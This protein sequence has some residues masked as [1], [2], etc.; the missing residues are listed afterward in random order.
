MIKEFLKGTSK[1]T[2]PVKLQTIVIYSH[3]PPR[4]ITGWLCVWIQNNAGG[5]KV[6]QLDFG[7]GDRYV[8]L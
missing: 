2:L 1:N 3:P 7:E 6:E 4:Q 5:R 8:R